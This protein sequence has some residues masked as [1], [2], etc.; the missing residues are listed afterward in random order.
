M[1]WYQNFQDGPEYEARIRKGSFVPPDITLKELHAAVPKH[2]FQ[3]STPKSLFYVFRHLAFTYAFYVF[4]TYI[5]IITGFVVLHGFIWPG[6]AMYFRLA[7]WVTYWGWQGITFAGIWCLGHE[8]GHNALS[9]HNSVNTL[10][11]L[12]LHTFVLTPYYAWR[13][14][15]RT[16]HKGTN[17]LGRDETYLPPTRKDFKLGDGKVMVRMDYAE[18]LEETPLFTLTKMFIRQFLGFQLYLLHNRKGNR[19]YPKGTSHYRPSSALF[20]DDER[21]LIVA[22]NIAILSMLS[23]LGMYAHYTSWSNLMV[24]YIM[25]WLFC[26]N[27]M[28]TF[29]Y[30]Q[31]SDPTVP[32][33]RENEWTFARGALATVDRPLFGWVGRFFLH[34][35]STDHLAHHFFVSVP[36]YNLPKVTEA[37]KPVL[38][39]YY[40][41]DSTPVLWALWRSFTQCTFIEDEGDI[42][43]FKNQHGEAVMDVKNSSKSKGGVQAK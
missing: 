9:P 13:A 6:L 19:K 7:L 26:H 21:H 28:V 29:T 36:F 22:S 20:R 12:P 38:G 1:P 23:L 3:A 16:H 24:Y 42:V 5:D 10:I 2:L 25:P 11:G 4:A 18:V 43:F 32:Y 34:N 17:H 8:A 15:H 37:I 35:I 41:Y 40:N 30:L 27:W 33:Y 31:H 39:E 14:T